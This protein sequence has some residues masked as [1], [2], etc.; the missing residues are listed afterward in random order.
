MFLTAPDRIFAGLKPGHSVHGVLTITDVHFGVEDWVG[1][2]A[3]VACLKKIT[4]IGNFV[5]DAVAPVG[6][7]P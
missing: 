7:K 1:P 5:P 4:I 3:S 2:D 6:E